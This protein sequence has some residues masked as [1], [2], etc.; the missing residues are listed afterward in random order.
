MTSDEH[1]ARQGWSFRALHERSYYWIIQRSVK[2]AARRAACVVV[3]SAKVR[4]ELLE[5]VTTVTVP[6]FVVHWGIDKRW[7]ASHGVESRGS[8]ASITGSDPPFLLCVNPHTCRNLELLVSAI[9]LHNRKQQPHVVLKVVGHLDDLKD[10]PPSVQHLGRV[11]DAQLARLYASALAMGITVTGSGFGLPLLEAMASG[12]PCIVRAGT[13]EA[14]IAAGHGVYVVG[15][16][17]TSW[18]DVVADLTSRPWERE[19]LSRNAA[20]W[21]ATF[22]WK[23]VGSDLAGV[24]E[25]ARGIAATPG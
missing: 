18:A 16:D 20:S 13:A 7:S 5:V 9:D 14:E 19:R 3:P 1:Y 23:R 17:P 12:C 4:D 2:I 22:S 25:S 8:R 15:S 6:L 21:A 24:I 10:L 11:S